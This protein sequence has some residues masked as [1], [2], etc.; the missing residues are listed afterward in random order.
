MIICKR[1]VH[2][3]DHLQEAGPLPGQGGQRVAEQEEGRS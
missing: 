1:I 3:N 2:L